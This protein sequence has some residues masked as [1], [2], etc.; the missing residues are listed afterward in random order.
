RYGALVPRARRRA[1]SDGVKALPGFSRL[2]ALLHFCEGGDYFER[3]GLRRPHQG[4]TRGDGIAAD[5]AELD[6]DA[7]GR[8]QQAQPHAFA[9]RQHRAIRRNVTDDY[10]IAN[11][12]VELA[13][14]D[15]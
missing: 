10:V 3:E 6:A 11:E 1:P 15:V 12:R 8:L 7:V 14:A 4:D 13:P 9:V 2:K 5:E